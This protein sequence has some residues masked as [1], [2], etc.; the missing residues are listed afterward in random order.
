M[1]VLPRLL[2]IGDGFTDPYVADAITA[3]VGAG[4]PWVQLR[5]HG[6]REERF[7]A[8]A[9]K[10]IERLRILN[11]DVILSINSR[12][13][14][15]RALSTGL[16]LR[17]ME[18]SPEDFSGLPIG[19]SVHSRSEIDT[20]GGDY[21]LFSPIFPTQSKPGHR[22]AGLAALNAVCRAVFMPV[23]A[24]GGMTP[25]RIRPCR[26]AGA[27]GVAVL[28]GILEAGNIEKRVSEYLTALERIT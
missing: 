14:A 9:R 8:Q 2:L 27:Y 24:M 13:A 16:H 17:S 20:F 4:V 5:D 21:L 6:P 1:S 12:Q 26:E 10:L 18:E 11:P 28:S 19:K 22:G 3:A 15:A 7:L 23:I 25:E